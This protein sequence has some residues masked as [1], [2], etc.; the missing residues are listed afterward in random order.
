MEDILRDA[1]SKLNKFKESSLK[2]RDSGPSEALVK[3]LTDRH[4]REKQTA[5]AE[6]ESI[7]AKFATREKELES[8]HAEK[9]GALK[10]R[11]DVTLRWAIMCVRFPHP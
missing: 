9:I 7:K 5:L 3:A 10:V 8:V 2:Q 6:L 4:D 11:G 1:A